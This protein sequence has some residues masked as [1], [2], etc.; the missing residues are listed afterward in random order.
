MIH[1]NELTYRSGDRLLFDGATLAVAQGHKI[2]I[3]GPNGSGK[4]TLFRLIAGEAQPESGSIAIPAR[5]RLGRV[6]QE[7]PSGSE[8][9][10]ETVLAADGERAHLLAAA[11]TESDPH[12]I[13]DIHARLAEIGAH[14]A[15]AR[16]AAI[17]AGLGFDEA[18]QQRPCASFSGGWRMRVAL[19][20]ALFA[21]PDLLLLDEPTNH[22][23]LEAAM[24]LEGHLAS[25]PGTLLLISHDR[26]LLNRA[27]D[28]IAHLDGGKLVRYRGGY[29]D[30]ERTR[31]ARIEQEGKLRTR[32]L[33]ERRRIMAFVD[34]FRAKA[35][36]ARQA[37]SRLKLLE[38]MEPVAAVVEARATAFAFPPPR[39]LAPPL[40]TFDGVE[41]G[42]VPGQPVLRNLSLSLGA[43]DRIALLGAN[44]N[45]KSTLMRLLAGRLAPL[46]G[47]A[48]R[49][50]R[51]G[52][53]YFAQHQMEELSPD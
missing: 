17:L 45:G 51:L 44:G 32:Q 9:L 14:A 12:R 25:W 1:I 19:A 27:V 29:D 10:I 11:E 48:T 13:A 37:Q 43:D 34:R 20:A 31:A 18:A 36:K 41:A 40:V 50:A 8:S 35:T 2:G 5:V 49:A 6:A 7:A 39:A 46:A 16:A 38:R 26:G 47:E 4:T 21:Q 28:G 33:E 53:G 15:P 23:D 3:V 22:L 52:V 42:Y 24:W 30:F